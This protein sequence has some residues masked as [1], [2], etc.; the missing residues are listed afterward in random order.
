MR[1]KKIKLTESEKEMG[2]ILWPYHVACAKV[3]YD[4]LTDEEKTKM[5]NDEKYRKKKMFWILT[6]IFPKD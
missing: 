6:G 1:K 4:S 2:K 3:R 5:K